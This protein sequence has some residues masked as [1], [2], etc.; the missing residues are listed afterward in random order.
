[1]ST[2]TTKPYLPL[3]RLVDGNEL[4][5]DD[6]GIPSSEL[7]LPLVSVLL[8]SGGATKRYRRQQAVS[9]DEPEQVKNVR[10]VGNLRP[11]HSSLLPLFGGGACGWCGGVPFPFGATECSG[12]GRGDGRRGGPPSSAALGRSSSAEDGSGSEPWQ[13]LSPRN[14]DRRHASPTSLTFSTLCMATTAGMSTATTKPY[15][16]L[17]RLVDGNELGRDDGGIPS[18]ELRLPLVSVLLGSGRATKRYRRQ[19]DVSDDEPEQV[20]NVRSVGNLRQRHSSLLPLFGGG[21]CGWCGGVPFPFGATECSG[22][23]RGD[24]RRGGP[25]S[26]AALGRSS[27]AEHGS[28][29]TNSRKLRPTCFEQQPWRFSASSLPSLSF[30]NGVGS[31]PWQ[32]LSPRNGDRR[33]AS[34]TSLTFSTLCMATTAGMSTATTKPYLPLPRLVDGNELGRDDGGIPSSELRLPLVSVLLGSGRATKRYR[35]Q[36]DVSDDEPEQVKNVRSVG[37]LRQRHSSL[38]PLFGGGA[39]GWCGGVPFPFGATECSGAGRGDGRRGGPPSSAALGRSSSAEHGSGSD[40]R[41]RRPAVRRFGCGGAP[42]SDCRPPA[43]VQRCGGAA[44][45]SAGVLR[46]SGSPGVHR[47]CGSAGDLRDSDDL[48]GIGGRWRSA[49]G[50]TGTTG[51]FGFGY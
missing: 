51:D 39:C 13:R 38:L 14:G 20:K 43:A 47:G 35:R 36:Q 5:R 9:D 6:G 3:P 17:P 31:E 32:R 48:R 16:P 28:A 23:G 46:G 24:G 11:R 49:T 12:A 34:P 26:S 41:L 44:S 19:Q 50:T 37:N 42:S 4:G 29:G 15:L 45:S 10:S 21:A 40:D 33:H 22:A 1:M 27:S 30:A 2:A 18:S 8:G 25:P 7:R